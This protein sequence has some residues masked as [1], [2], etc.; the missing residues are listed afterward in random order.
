MRKD[1]GGGDGDGDICNLY[2][3]E[4][5][6]MGS[7]VQGTRE[8]FGHISNVPGTVDVVPVWFYG[9]FHKVSLYLFLF[10]FFKSNL[11]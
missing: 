6:S 1:D 5:G 9:L 3:H 4:T 10:S 7:L 2:L 8:R 11:N